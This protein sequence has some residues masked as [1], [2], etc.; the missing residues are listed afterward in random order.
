MDTALYSAINTES[1]V[2][3]C[4]THSANWDQHM[5]D[6]RMALSCLRSANI[7]FWRDKCRLGYDTVKELQRFLGMADFYR[8]YIPAFAQ[9]SEPLYQLTRKGHAWDWNGERQSSF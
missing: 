8:D 5:S 7:Q 9:I 1:Y 2:D 4:L 3:D 6:L